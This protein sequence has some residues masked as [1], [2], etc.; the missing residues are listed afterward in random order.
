MTESFATEIVKQFKAYGLRVTVDNSSES[1][2]KKIRASEIMKVPYTLVIGQ[3]EIES[4]K[5]IARIRADLSSGKDNN[6]LAVSE[7]LKTV[8][9][10]ASSRASKST[11]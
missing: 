4:N 11:L 9:N 5:V 3:K 2:G 7:F 6:E 10:E 8:A 1:V